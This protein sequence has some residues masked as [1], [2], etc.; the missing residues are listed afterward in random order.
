MRDEQAFLRDIVE[1]ARMVQRFVSGKTFDDFQ[2]D[3]LLQEGVLRRLGIIGEAAS[4]IPPETLA[5]IDGP[6]WKL[7]IRMRNVLAHIYFGVD[8][9]I[10]WDTANTDMAPLILAVESHLSSNSTGSSS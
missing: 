10:A 5:K 3:S 4:K 6:P 1:S 9:K 7:I 8:L 2:N